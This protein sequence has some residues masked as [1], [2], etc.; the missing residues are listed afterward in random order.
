MNTDMPEKDVNIIGGLQT[1]TLHIHVISNT[2][3]GL[4]YMDLKK[5]IKKLYGFYAGNSNT[6]N[7]RCK[8]SIGNSSL[9][10]GHYWVSLYIIYH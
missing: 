6:F 7:F 9:H 1:E 10:S 5:I 3:A 4:L 8:R 2:F